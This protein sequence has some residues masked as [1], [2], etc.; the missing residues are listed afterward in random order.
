MPRRKP[1]QNTTEFICVGHLLLDLGLTLSVVY[2]P[3]RTLLART[4][5]P[6]QAV[7]SE[8]TSGLV[9]GGLCL[10]P[11]LVLGHHLAWI[12]AGCVHASL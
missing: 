5:S 11:L 10:P 6:L 8:V 7:V 9:N 1:S 4:S 12:C 2:T 3:S